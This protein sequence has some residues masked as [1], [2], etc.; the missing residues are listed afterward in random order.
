MGAEHFARPGTEETEVQYTPDGVQLNDYL[1]P[2]VIAAKDVVPVQG[3]RG[4][5]Q[6]PA[7]ADEY[8]SRQSLNY[9]DEVRGTV[10]LAQ[11]SVVLT[12]PAPTIKYIEITCPTSSAVD[13]YVNLNGNRA[14][15]ANG[16]LQVRIG[17]TR[18]YFMLINQS[19]Q[20]S[21]DGVGTATYRITY[22]W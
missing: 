22:M 2:P 21:G 3:V 15:N 17:E 8:H 10:T 11:G 1:V 5:I 4:V 18:G 9:A 12:L 19:I 20:I 13:L 16:S 7:N 6:Y 14:G